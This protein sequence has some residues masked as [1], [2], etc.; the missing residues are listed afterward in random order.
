MDVLKQSFPDQKKATE[1]VHKTIQDEITEVTNEMVAGSKKMNEKTSGLKRKMYQFK[2]EVLNDLEKLRRRKNESIYRDQSYRFLNTY[3][4][5]YVREVYEKEA[6]RITR[7]T[8]VVLPTF[9]SFM[10]LRERLLYCL[11]QENNSHLTNE[12]NNTIARLK[13]QGRKREIKAVK[14]P[15]FMKWPATEDDIDAYN[16]KAFDRHYVRFEIIP[17]GFGKYVELDG[18]CVTW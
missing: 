17:R 18:R 5:T 2:H 13:S 12:Y 3:I 9:D 4:D 11:V 16:D 1:E 14:K 6:D 7:N 15:I 10:R 8:S